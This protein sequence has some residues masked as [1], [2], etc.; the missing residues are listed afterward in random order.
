MSR[1]NNLPIKAYSVPLDEFPDDFVEKYYIIKQRILKFL[2]TKI[3]YVDGEAKLNASK[4]DY[5]YIRDSIS[6]DWRWTRHYI[7]SALLQ[8]SGMVYGWVKRYNKGKAH[9]QPEIRNKAVY[10]KNT[11]FTVKNN[12]I[13]ISLIPNKQYLEVNL[14][15]YRYIPKDYTEIGGLTYIPEKKRLVINFKR[16]AV[17][18]KPLKYIGIDVNLMNITIYIPDTVPGIEYY[19]LLKNGDLTKT[20]GYE[21]KDSIQ[22]FRKVGG[23]AMVI[24]ISIL[25]NIHK[26][27]ELK[28][29]RLQELSKKK[30]KTMKRVMDKYSRREK[31]RVND[32][33]H[34]LTKWLLKYFSEKQYG[35][36]LE[37]LNKI[38]ENTIANGN[39]DDKSKDTKRKLGKWN[40]RK[41]QN[42]LK[43]KLQWNGI[44]VDDVN[45]R[46]TSH[47]C[48]IC[49][50]KMKEY[51]HRRMKCTHCGLIVDRDVTAA[52]NIY[53]RG[54][55]NSKH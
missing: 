51:N 50:N 14:N 41:L 26:T 21:D 36:F 18:V 43:Y 46:N 17:K 5:R 54:L 22:L 16:D 38:K 48:P 35:V 3:I 15:N 44:Y 24:D 42:T 25:Y 33:V 27:Y 29:G 19:K 6:E 49:G 23:K 11:L 2:L 45:P 31:R 40:A 47:K 30:P 55:K 7:D 52:I 8:V 34:K 20:T 32:L 12:I 39:G 53:H 13:K 1:R 28:R 37:N 10:I 9:K 4:E